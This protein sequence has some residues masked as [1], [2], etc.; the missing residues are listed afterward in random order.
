P[1]AAWWSS[2]RS[3]AA[4]TG[5]VVLLGVSLSLTG[6]LAFVDGGAL[7]YNWRDGHA[8]WVLAASR[9]VNLTLALPS[10]FRG[11]LADIIR[12]ATILALAGAVGFA[13][14]ALLERLRLRP[15][16][17]ALATGLCAVAVISGGAAAGWTTT[18]HD[19]RDPG[20]GAIW[21]AGR[22]CGA[23]LRA[24]WT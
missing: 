15:G 20:A 23:G 7:V 18:G 16:A 2:P 14:L 11:D 17:W 5:A 22:A 3:R 9:A 1:M 8:L 6:V 19:P 12:L 10:F 24:Y 21:V 13:V 4:T